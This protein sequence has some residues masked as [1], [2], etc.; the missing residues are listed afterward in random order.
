MGLKPSYLVH[1]GFRLPKSFPRERFASALDYQA[2]AGDIFVSAYPKCGTTWTQHIVYLLQCGGVPLGAGD[3]LTELF[4]HLEEVGSRFVAS[5][6]PPRCIKTHL[7]FAM[8]PYHRQARYIYVARNPFDCAVSFF[9]HTPRFP[10][11]L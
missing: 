11:A 9:H 2:A 5:L 1:R 3:R 8:T 7:P 4:P 10:P 6:A